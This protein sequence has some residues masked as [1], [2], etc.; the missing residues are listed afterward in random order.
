MSDAVE[1]AV[2]GAMM[3]EMRL[4]QLANNMANINTVGFKADRLFE[5][6]DDVEPKLPLEYSDGR[7]LGGI[8]PRLAPFSSLPV[9]TTTDYSQGAMTQT[10]NPLD[11]A[12]EGEG[13]FTVETPDGVRFTRSGEFSVNA[14]GVLVTREGY[15]VQ[16]D[17]G[18]IQ[19]EPGTV[20]IDETG[21]IL[22]NEEAV[23]GLR[24]VRFP[25][26]TQLLK[27]GETLF[28]PANAGDTGTVAEDAK[29]HQGFLEKSNVDP[30]L[31][32]TEM[33]DAVRGFEAYQKVIQTLDQA[34]GQAVDQV[35]RLT[36]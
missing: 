7:S 11:V 31:A 15:K 32:M 18:E 20:T 17:G 4:N 23:G 14:D 9:S 13:F 2:T 6:P 26:E 25:K 28:A 19:I 16:G 24:I 29:V 21:Q 30:V 35:G 34:T 3:Q 8:D 22:V 12:L 36:Q 33:I 5:L 10:G 27:Q 1:G